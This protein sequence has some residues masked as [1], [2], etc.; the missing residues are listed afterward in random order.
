[1][2]TAEVDG[3]LAVDEYPQVVVAGK[4]KCLASVVAKFARELQ[5]E[6]IIVRATLI[7]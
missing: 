4:L 2:I 7:P 6:V 3:E 5:G 1:V